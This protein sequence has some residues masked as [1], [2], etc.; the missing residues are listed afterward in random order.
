MA[1]KTWRQFRR[2]VQCLLGFV[3]CLVLLTSSSPLTLGSTPTE[4]KSDRQVVS[5]PVADVC[6]NITAD[7]TWTAANSPYIVTCD[8]IVDAGVTLTIEPGVVVKFGGTYRDLKIDGTLL[9]EGTAAE[10]ITFTSLKDDEAGGDTNSDGSASSPWPGDWDGLRFYGSSTGSVLDHA[11]VRYGSGPNH[12]NIYV[13]TSDV[14]LTNNTIAYG[15][16]DG[17]YFDNALPPSLDNNSFTDNGRYAVYARLTDNGDSIALSGNTATGNLVNG[18]CVAGSIGGVV[19]WDGDETFPFVLID[20]LTIN[21]G[22]SLTLTPGT[23]FKGRSYTDA[24]KVNGALLAEGTTDEPI[25]FTAIADDEVGGD[26]NDDGAASSPAPGGWDALHFNSSSSGSVLDHTVVR[27]GSGP[28]HENIYVAT[29]EATIRRSE[30]YGAYATGIYVDNSSPIIEDN[31]IHDNDTGIE[32]RNGSEPTLRGNLILNNGRYGV[33]SGEGSQPILRTNSI[34]ANGQWGVYNADRMVEVDAILNWWGSATGPYNETSNPDGE[35]DPVSNHVLYT[36]WLRKPVA[37]T[38]LLDELLLGLQGPKTASPG[39]TVDLAVSYANLTAATVENAVLVVF[40]P[41]GTEYVDSTGGGIY[42]PQRHEV[43]WRLG[44]LASGS[45]GSL[46]ARA[47]FLWGLPDGLSDSAAAKL[48]G[49]N[50]SQALL[51]VQPYLDYVPRLVTERVQLSEA[52]LEAERQAHPEFDA[53]YNQAIARELIFGTAE[54]LSW[55]DGAATTQ[56]VFIQPEQD[57]VM[58]IRRSDEGVTASTHERDTYTIQDSSGGMT[59][60]LTGGGISLFDGWDPSEEMGAAG[61]GTVQERPGRLI[62]FANCLKTKLPE[63]LIKRLGRITA[64]IVNS[65]YC[66]KCMTDTSSC[67]TCAE[68]LGIEWDNDDMSNH[69]WQCGHSVEQ[70]PDWWVC[71]GGEEKYTHDWSVMIYLTTGRDS[72]RVYFCNPTTGEWTSGSRRF[73]HYI[74]CSNTQYCKPGRGEGFGCVTKPEWCAV[75]EVAGSSATADT[76]GTCSISDTTVRAAK[77]PNEKYGPAGDLLPGQTLTYTVACENEGAGTAYGVYIV[78][79]LSKHLD[80][81]SVAVYGDGELIPDTSVLLWDIGELA[82]KGQVGSQD[83]VSFTVRL[84]D[85]L[86]SGTVIANEAVVYFPSVPEETPTN[87]LVNVVQPLVAFPQWLQVEAGQPLAITLQ[88]RDAIGTPLTYTIAEGPLLGEISGIAPALVYTP[89]INYLGLD[90]FTFQVSNGITESRPAEVSI[91]VNPWSGDTILPEVV[92]TYPADGAQVVEVSATPVYTDALGPV[93]NP[94][95]LFD[96]SEVVDSTTV[97]G[98]TVQLV[99][100]G[101]PPLATTVAS[102]GSFG[103]WVILPREPL[104]IGARYTVNVSREVTDLMG[105]SMAA[106]YT[107]SFRI[108]PPQPPVYLPLI[109]SG[110][111]PAG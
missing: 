81:S 44:D 24:L 4:A 83:A 18:F 64:Q 100:A 9:A 16:N 20:D 53:F 101:G 61:G 46:V 75:L 27:Y 85:D 11:V 103:R 67:F 40:L 88:G 28:H 102:S 84:K 1:N 73:G 48:N 37:E 79:E 63:D 50:L 5:A 82:P 39:Q 62:R 12:E 13:A 36:P 92:W 77:D 21:Q 52:E 7:T 58:I 54:R 69:V 43:F 104:W 74:P 109:S 35:G 38:T 78:D 110:A 105:N 99:R 66:M 80:T 2:P 70:F 19:S 10:P 22:A 98:Q 29:S 56:A 30:V 94:F 108:T 72:C 65:R 106:D 71:H 6:G 33:Y 89:P 8:V 55:S 31:I 97:S 60:D 26:T 17:L 15:Y 49:A 23:V 57:T 25:T 90:H 111:R 45:S 14:T 87:P 34:M 96:F 95:V 41:K 32:V 59:L 76:F 91:V 42:W 93:Y 107:W 47:R 3:L 68:D 86:P 51:E